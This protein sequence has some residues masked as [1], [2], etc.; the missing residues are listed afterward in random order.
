MATTP[1]SEQITHKPL[2]G[3]AIPLK[4]YLDELPTGGGS[5]EG[6]LFVEAF[7]AIGDGI[8]D[9]TAAFVAANAAGL[10]FAIKPTTY[11]IAGNN[12]IISVP[13][14]SYGG[15][16]NITGSNTYV[17]N[18]HE[19]AKKAVGRTLYRDAGEYTLTPTTYTNLFD[20]AANHVNHYSSLGYQQVFTSDAGGRTM[21]P[22]FSTDGSHLGYGDVSSFYGNWGIS[23]H[24]SAAS[25]SNSWTGANS[26]TIVAGQITAI[27][28]RT[29]LYGAEFHLVDNGNDR[30]AANGLV[31]N[32]VK[33]NPTASI[34]GA[35]KTVWTGV[36]IQTGG[37]Y[38]CDSALSVNGKWRIGLD[39]TGAVFP[40]KAAMALKTDDRL[41]F[42]CAATVAPSQWYSEALS[43]NYMT[44]DG[45]K[46]TLVT[47]GIAAFQSSSTATTIIG[48]TSIYKGGTLL[49]D[50]ANA[51]AN[52]IFIGNAGYEIELNQPVHLTGQTVSS[53]ATGGGAS[54]LPANPLTYLS[55]KIDGATYKL[56]VY[57]V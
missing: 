50:I 32:F 10:P 31:L 30:V 52:K 36:R 19:V 54:P 9:D 38:D 57:N 4:Q 53:A 40:N 47:G 3:S 7:G 48:G 45:T 6:L 42:G 15:T 39:V 28:D 43:D 25:I 20:F 29:N 34:T 56:P 14:L 23:K 8:T 18:K 1:T 37:T 24:P 35:Y 11:L 12:V 51:V 13:V 46:F 41:Y 55:I 26:G 16:L 5:G 21:Q 17:R 49:V 27:T 33:N 44:F 2:V 22:S